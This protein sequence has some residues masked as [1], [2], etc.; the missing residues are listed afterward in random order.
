MDQVSK[1]H[2]SFSSKTGLYPTACDRWRKQSDN[3]SIG[4]AENISWQCVGDTP[5]STFRAEKPARMQVH[6]ARLDGLASVALDDVLHGDH[7]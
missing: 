3:S 2:S 1:V 5:P 7:R 4:E 6:S